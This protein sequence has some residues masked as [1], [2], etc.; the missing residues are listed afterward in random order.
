MSTAFRQLSR[1]AELP[2]TKPAYSRILVDPDGFL[3]VAD[4]PAHGDQ[5]THWKVFDPEGGWLGTVETPYGGYIHQIGDD[6]LLGIWVD[7]L[8]VE[9]VRMYRIER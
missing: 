4:Y 6:F 3:W 2:E 8:D 1:D 5:H 9:Q 7:E